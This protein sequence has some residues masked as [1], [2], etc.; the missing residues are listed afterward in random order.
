MDA[1]FAVVVSTSGSACI[2]FQSLDKQWVQP[3]TFTDM[4]IVLSVL[5]VCRLEDV[6]GHLVQVRRD[7]CTG[8]IYVV[9]H[10]TGNPWVFPGASED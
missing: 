7:E 4:K 9:G 5:G 6:K 3:C 10:Y 1:E 8:I 2:W